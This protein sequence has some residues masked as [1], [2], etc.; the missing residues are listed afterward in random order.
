MT[1]V[2]FGCFILLVLPT[3]GGASSGFLH[4]LPAQTLTRAQKSA[5]LAAIE[6]ALG[7]KHRHATEV[8]L[9]PLEELLMTTLN[10]LPRN[11]HGK[12]GQ[13]AARYAL[14]RLFVQRHAWFV[15]G[16][17]LNGDSRNNTNATPTAML[18][19][20]VP[21][22]VQ[23]LLESRL[24]SEGLDAHEIAVMAAT[25]ENLAHAESMGRLR[26]AYAVKGLT[27]AQTQIPVDVVDSLLDVYMAGY[28]T[29]LDLSEFAGSLQTESRML[30]IA[31][32]YYPGFEDVRQFVRD[33]RKESIPH[34]DEL[35][36][37]D[38]SHIVTRI[39]DKYGRW[40]HHECDDLKRKLLAIEDDGT[41]RVSL[42]KFYGSAINHGHW[43]FSETPDYLRSLGALDESIPTNPRV[44][45]PNYILAPT[46]C[47]ASSSYYS[48]CCLDECEE[49]VDHVERAI[50]APAAKP[51][52]IA[53]I[54]AALPSS[55][56]PANRTISARLLGRLNDIAANN[57]GLVPLHARMFAQ[58]MHHVYPRE[59]PFPHMSGTFNALRMEDYAKETGFNAAASEDEMRQ[60]V[61]D[62][63][64][65]E[66]AGEIIWSDQDE[67][68]VEQ[69][70]PRY[71]W[72]RA[73][74]RFVVFFGLG[75]STLSY[76]LRLGRAAETEYV[77]KGHYV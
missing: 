59:C 23:T 71:D 31:E 63:S 56:T 52:R 25:F 60:C 19:E 75:L 64:P 18:Q 37:V 29:G 6:E 1:S 30:A 28:V 43:Q 41:G 48:V 53:S 27:Q 54:V 46:N 20:G 70:P 50:S 38:V 67:F 45:V 61:A 40:Q 65:A 3:F 21:D 44:I 22:E 13:K 17:D 34:R 10:A 55:T 15:K 24:G 69:A 68:Y 4:P 33:V 76:L 12:F 16:V 8:R 74:M 5:V 32:A 7:E 77:S 66:E 51:A 47:V 36:F 39:G 26:S 9:A 14:H 42:T 72:G 58:W 11:A 73:S 2:A 49:L 57:D 35:S 62:A